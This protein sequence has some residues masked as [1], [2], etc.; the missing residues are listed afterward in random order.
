MKLLKKHM[1]QL[2]YLLVNEDTDECDNDLYF[3]NQF[4]FVPGRFALVKEGDTIEDST[5]ING[6]NYFH[7]AHLCKQHGPIILDLVNGIAELENAAT[8]N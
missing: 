2:M 1:E 7:E 8:N 4:C 6:D 5:N 3:Q